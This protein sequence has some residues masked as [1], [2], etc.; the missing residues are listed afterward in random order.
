LGRVLR[1]GGKLL[2]QASLRAAAVRNEITE[3]VIETIFSAWQIEH[4]E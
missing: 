4:M 1:P 2:L 3:Q